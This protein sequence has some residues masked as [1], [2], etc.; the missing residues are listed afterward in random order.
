M[1]HYYPLKI[2]INSNKTVFNP[3]K[4]PR[5]TYGRV[6]VKCRHS[7]ASCSYDWRHIF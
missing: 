4:Q 5:D 1:E 3:E 7:G 2:P 6:P